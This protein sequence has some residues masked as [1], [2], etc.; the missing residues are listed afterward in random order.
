[1]ELY[2]GIHVIY[3]TLCNDMIYNICN[4]MICNICNMICP[5]FYSRILVPTKLNHPRNSIIQV[6]A[7]LDSTKTEPSEVVA[8]LNY[9]S[10]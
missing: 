8:K 3:A 5:N 2:F 1:M 10:L 9:P 6:I 4:D 7:K